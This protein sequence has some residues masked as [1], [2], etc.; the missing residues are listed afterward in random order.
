MRP[1]PAEEPMVAAAAA[2]ALAPPLKPDG[3][4]GGAL[5]PAIEGVGGGSGVPRRPSSVDQVPGTSPPRRASVICAR[6]RTDDETES[7]GC[8][9]ARGCGA[10]IE[11]VETGGSAGWSTREA[12]SEVERKGGGASG[13]SLG[14]GGREEEKGRE[15][16][17]ERGRRASVAAGVHSL[18]RRM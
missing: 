6:A 13:T 18:V 1:T 5:R 9:C 7:A 15:E 11:E 8:A 14:D 10:E 17:G 16:S 4:G 3:G 2:R 12:L